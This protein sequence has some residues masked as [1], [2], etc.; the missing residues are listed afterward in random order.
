MQL[1]QIDNEI[2]L[3]RVAQKVNIFSEKLVLTQNRMTDIFKVWS[4]HNTVPL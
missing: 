4:D 2:E 1:L 3:G